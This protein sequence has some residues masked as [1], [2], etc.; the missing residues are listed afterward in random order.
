MDLRLKAE[1]FRVTAE[2]L[3]AAEFNVKSDLE[4]RAGL[5]QRSRPT[6]RPL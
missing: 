1:Q 4:E 3:I 2:L 6:F 5:R